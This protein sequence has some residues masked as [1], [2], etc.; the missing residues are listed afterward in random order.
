[1]SDKLSEIRDI[2]ESPPD[3]LVEALEAAGITVLREGPVWKVSDATAARAIASAHN[4]L[5]ALKRERLAR[6]DEAADVR[7]ALPAIMRAGSATNV[8]AAQISGYLASATNRY[9][10]LRAAVQNAA[11]ATALRAIDFT[12]GWPANP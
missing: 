4:P 8:T 9:R 11:D 12:T 10:I 6:L 1:M 7:L 5:P 2:P 3:G